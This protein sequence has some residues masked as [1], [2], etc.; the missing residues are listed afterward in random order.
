MFPINLIYYYDCY[1]RN[2]NILRQMQ[3]K[4]SR[5]DTRMATLSFQRTTQKMF[6]ANLGGLVV[7][8]A[9]GQ[10]SLWNWI[11]Q[12]SV[13]NQISIFLIESFVLMH[14]CRQADWTDHEENFCRCL[15]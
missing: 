9:L 12:V 14:L 13:D 4:E 2:E 15:W 5:K 6:C 7:K 3:Y 1:C 8:K 10:I 11:C